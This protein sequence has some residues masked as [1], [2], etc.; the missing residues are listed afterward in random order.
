[1]TLLGPF[2]PGWLS[3]AVLWFVLHERLYG[4]P[5]YDLAASEI[6]RKLRKETPFRF[7][8]R[9]DQSPERAREHDQAHVATYDRVLLELTPGEGRP[10]GWRAGFYEVGERREVVV[11]ILGEPNVGGVKEQA[12]KNG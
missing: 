7:L 4:F 8:C 1:M 10:I 3:M 2:L 5:A 12:P 9:L 11:K 6:I